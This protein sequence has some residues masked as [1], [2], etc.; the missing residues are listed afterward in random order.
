MREIEERM[1]RRG[2]RNSRAD[3]RAVNLRSEKR[4]S[5]EKNN[6]AKR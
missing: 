5:R 1:G 2:R 3:P 6:A 4:K